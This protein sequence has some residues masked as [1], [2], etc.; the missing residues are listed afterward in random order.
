MSPNRALKKGKY[1]PAFY[2][3]F[4]I[5]TTKLV[6]S[7]SMKG[8]YYLIDI[9]ATRCKPCIDEL[10]N[11]VNEFNNTEREKINFI[12]I[13]IDNNSS[14]P[15]R[16]VKEKF[17]LPWIMAISTRRTELMRSLM[18]TGIPCTILIDPKG[19]IVSYG[20]ELRGSNLHKTL[21]SIIN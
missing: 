13:S 2:Y 4:P 18:I 20:Y 12:S 3:S 5:D 21:A 10:P 17:A 7:S 8:K 19:Q 11:L 15:R 14:L 16:F 9:W 1:L 6:S